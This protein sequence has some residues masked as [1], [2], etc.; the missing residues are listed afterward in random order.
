MTSLRVAHFSDTHVLSLEGVRARRFLNKRWTGAVNLALNRARHYR[1]EVFE[2]LLEAVVAQAPDHVICTGDLVNLAL[3]PEFVRVAGMLRGAFRPDQLTVVPGNHDAYARDA[4]VEGLFERYFGDFQPDD[5]GVAGPRYPVTRVLPGLLI[6]GL[7]T[8][9]PTPV[10]MASGRLGAEQVEAMTAAFHADAATDRF[11]LL[12]LHHPL[13]P[14]PEQRLDVMRRLGDASALIG[15]LRALGPRAPQL[16]VHGHNHAFK[17]Q[18]LPG[19]AMPLVQV[20][21]AS[22]F[23][24]RHAA[25]F[26]VYVVQDGALTAIERHRHD[27]QTGRFVPRDPDGVALAQGA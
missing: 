27:P 4:V 7:S 10:F 17:S 6:V 25:E 19:A 26:N 12:M 15:A 3:E 18:R 11:R 14:D 16:V 1:V 5:L 2:A 9:I 13:L 21:S 8:A 23:G 24:G 22:R 20:A